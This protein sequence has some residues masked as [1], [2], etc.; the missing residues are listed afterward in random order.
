MSGELKIHEIVISSKK[1][2][3]KPMCQCPLLF[4]GLGTFYLNIINYSNKKEC[5]M[6]SME[7]HQISMTFAN[8]IEMSVKCVT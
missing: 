4:D 8:W 5:E 7:M 1:L 6:Q 3:K 2:A